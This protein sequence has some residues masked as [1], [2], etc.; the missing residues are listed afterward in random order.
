M[1]QVT[2]LRFFFFF[3]FLPRQFLSMKK[4]PKSSCLSQKK[5]CLP[6]KVN[7][8][9]D[10][11]ALFKHENLYYVYSTKFRKFIE[12]KKLMKCQNDLWKS[13]LKK[14]W[15]N[16]FFFPISSPNRTLLRVG[17]SDVEFLKSSFVTVQ[18]LMVCVTQCHYSQNTVWFIIGIKLTNAKIGSLKRKKKKKEKVPLRVELVTGLIYY[19]CIN[20]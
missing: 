17:K 15:C 11:K 4:M 13:V 1:L 18:W 3:T 16:D 2:Y 6:L 7:L 10:K 14:S 5:N 12:R 9:F 8:N 20:L 19:L